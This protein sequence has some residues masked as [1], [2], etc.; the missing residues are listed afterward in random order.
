MFVVGWGSCECVKGSPGQGE[1]NQA[2][3]LDPAVVTARS[4]P[5]QA[6]TT[7][8]SLAFCLHLRSQE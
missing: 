1:S 5:Q 8:H 6:C 3:Q 7:L 4:A 2:S